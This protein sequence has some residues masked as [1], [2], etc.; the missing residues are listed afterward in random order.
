MDLFTFHGD[1][2]QPRHETENFFSRNK[3]WQHI[4]TC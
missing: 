4:V 1:V 3:A 2:Q